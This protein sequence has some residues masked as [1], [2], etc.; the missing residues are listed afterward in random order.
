MKKI[1]PQILQNLE[2]QNQEKSSSQN[3]KNILALDYGEKFCGLAFSP[4]GICT[5]P[6][7]VV[8]T[9]K[10]EE[11]MKEV[12]NKKCVQGLVVGLPIL[13]NGQENKLCGIIREFVKQFEA[14]VPVEFVNERF[15]SKLVLPQKADRIDDFAAVKILEF[16]FSKK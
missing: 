13:P 10:I 16:S 8:P 6:L 11:K 3:V 4:D 9:E 5:F 14:L 7:E 2:L 12:L 15:S 1:S